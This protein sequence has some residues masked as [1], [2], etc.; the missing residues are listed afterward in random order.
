MGYYVVSEYDTNIKET[1]KKG[2]LID[3]DMIR[4]EKKEDL[5]KYVLD[6]LK[7]DVQ[8]ANSELRSLA[9]QTKELEIWRDLRNTAMEE[10]EKQK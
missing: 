3:L 5:I 2:D 8:H 4:Y 6:I 1:D 10:F 9:Q 7:E